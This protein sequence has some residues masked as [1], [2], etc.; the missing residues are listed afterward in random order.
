[1]GLTLMI[2]G[3]NVEATLQLTAIDSKYPAT[4]EGS[5]DIEILIETFR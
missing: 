5:A 1:M 2:H 3:F 4:L